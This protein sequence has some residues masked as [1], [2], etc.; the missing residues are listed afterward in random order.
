MEKSNN[1]NL[2]ENLNEAI[3]D[4]KEYVN[5]R[6]QL[7]QLNVTEKVSIGLAGLIAGGIA[8]ILFVLCFIFGSFALAY[9]LGNVLHN[10][11]AGF[12]VMAGF[13]LLLGI[14]MLK[15]GKG[16]LRIT[17][18]NSFIKQFSND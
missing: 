17:L 7:I 16:K 10:T 4:V 1:P 5:L 11:A 12:G 2:S 3:D 6:M 15:V 18:I 8:L 14:I 13:Y 9:L